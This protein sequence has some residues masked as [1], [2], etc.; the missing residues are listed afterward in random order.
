MDTI[1]K[2]ITIN[3]ILGCDDSFNNEIIGLSLERPILE[4]R[5]KAAVHVDYGQI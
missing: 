5:A 1:E 3:H 2:A 4:A